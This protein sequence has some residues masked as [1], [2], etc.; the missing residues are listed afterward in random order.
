MGKKIVFCNCKGDDAE[1]QGLK[2]I[3]LYLQ[4]INIQLINIHDLCGICVTKKNETQALFS[5]S[6]EFLVIAC[7]SRVVKLLLKSIDIDT[8]TGQ[9]T[10][11][12]VKEIRDGALTN[13]FLD[14]C[15]DEFS[16]KSFSNVESDPDWPS[17]YPLID[18][19]RCSACGQC[20][21]FCLFGVYKKYEGKINVINPKGCKNNCPACAR[22]CP[23]TA[24]VFPKYSGGGA[25]AGSEMVDEMEEQQ[26]QQMDMNA[27]LGSD[28]YKTLELRKTKRKSI[29]KSEAMNQALEERE[30]AWNKKTD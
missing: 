22:L 21:D 3:F 4:S 10:F 2:H 1:T 9:F 12:N 29:I 8:E 23:Q 14:F 18:Y 27:I 5:A 26:R 16:D 25:I 24:I 7:S 15:G 28:V 30:R 13:K 17:W 11:L 6:D 19:S 20:A